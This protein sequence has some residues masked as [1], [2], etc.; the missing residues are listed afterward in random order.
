[1]AERRNTVVVLVGKPV[2]VVPVVLVVV[3]STGQGVEAAW[4]P[5]MLVVLVVLTDFGVL[6]GVVLEARIVVLVM[7]LRDS[8]YPLILTSVAVV[9]V[10][11]LVAVL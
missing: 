3:L 4:V 5:A 11:V 2:P 1:V 6:A 8:Q 9:V 10:V 7:A